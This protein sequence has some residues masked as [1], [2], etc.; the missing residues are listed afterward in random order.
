M[1]VCPVLLYAPENEQATGRGYGKQAG[2]ILEYF[3]QP[4]VRAGYF[5]FHKRICGNDGGNAK[6]IKMMME[7]TGTA[8]T[9]ATMKQYSG[10]L[11]GTEMKEKKRIKKF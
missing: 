8:M 2:N 4:Y 6:G 7:G 11:M 5:Y 1:G 3:M 9:A 10:V